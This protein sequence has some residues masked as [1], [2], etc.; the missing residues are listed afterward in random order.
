MYKR[1]GLTVREEGRLVGQT[2]IE[3]TAAHKPV[4]FTLGRDPEVSYTRTVKTVSR[5]KTSEVYEVTYRLESSKKAPVQAEI[6]EYLYT[7]RIEV[8]GQGITKNGNQAQLTLTV[9]AGGTVSRSF[10]VTVPVNQ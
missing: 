10:T 5:S 3:E 6:A 9:P 7:N 1:Q 4:E 2:N 8:K